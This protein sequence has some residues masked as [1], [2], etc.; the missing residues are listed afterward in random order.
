MGHGR[1]VTQPRHLC[2]R[3]EGARGVRVRIGRAGVTLY[4]ARGGEGGRRRGV[5]GGGRDAA[6]GNYL[7]HFL[8][9]DE[10][11]G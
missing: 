1:L 5:G 9:E 8:H 2:V 3:G 7:T 6:V 4:T 11:W 10:V